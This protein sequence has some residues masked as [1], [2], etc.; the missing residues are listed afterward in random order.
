MCILS[1]FSIQIYSILF[2]INHILFY[3]VLILY[4]SKP[5]TSS[6][7]DQSDHLKTSIILQDPDWGKRVWRNVTNNKTWLYF[8]EVQYIE[9]QFHPH[10]QVAS[11][12]LTKLWMRGRV[13]LQ[14]KFKR[15][16]YMVQNNQENTWDVMLLP[17]IFR[18]CGDVTIVTCCRPHTYLR[19]CARDRV[20]D[21]GFVFSNVYV[22]NSPLCL[23][24]FKFW[25]SVRIHY[26]LYAKR[27]QE[28]VCTFE[29]LII[30]S[31][32]PPTHTSKQTDKL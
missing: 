26:L 15:S 25:D 7:T 30:A 9:V 8:L 13:I 2:Y 18:I 17:N 12:V 22:S 19:N 4:S 28:C 10:I 27:S 23:L 14:K 20:V 11:S 21:S 3:L 31:S 16:N 5:V 32:P 24:K 6:T 1:K 29:P